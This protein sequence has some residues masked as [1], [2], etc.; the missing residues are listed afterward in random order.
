MGEEKSNYKKVVVQ[1][2]AFVSMLL[3]ARQNPHQAVHGVLL[4]QADD[5]TLMTVTSAVPICHG[6]PV[7]PWIEA[8]LSLIEAT[9]GDDNNNN[10]IVGW[11]TAPL[12]LDDV[13]PGPV[14]LRMASILESSNS[15]S[16]S[17]GTT[18]IV[19]NNQAVAAACSQSTGGDAS[20]AVQAFGKDFGQQY[21]EKIPTVV[22]NSAKALQALREATDSSVPC[23]DFL[24]HLE[25]EAS[26]TWYPNDKLVQL[27]KKVAN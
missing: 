20:A 21:Q 22:T 1:P 18:L 26:T 5:G 13:R 6:T 27:V 12:L 3:H 23:P 7:Q 10:K 15:S 11:Y 2:E 4:G 8:S 24:D 17:V 14:A 19:L 9:Q 16:S 25:Q